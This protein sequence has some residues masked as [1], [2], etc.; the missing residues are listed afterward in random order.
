MSPPTF[1]CTLGAECEL[2]LSISASSVSSLSAI[3]VTVLT[4]SAESFGTELPK[5]SP[6]PPSNSCAIFTYFGATL[7]LH[8]SDVEVTQE[9]KDDALAKDGDD[10]D[11]DVL[12]GLEDAYV[13]EKQGEEW[14][15]AKDKGGCE[16]RKTDKGT[17]LVAVAFSSLTPL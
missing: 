4:G 12:K 7:L 10:D 3:S 11:P 1:R 2:R 8:P 6:L 16:E 5:T 14:R 17:E 9:M 13:A 15:E